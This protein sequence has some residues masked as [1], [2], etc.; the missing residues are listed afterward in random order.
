MT[1][2]VRLD[3]TLVRHAAAEGAVHR[4]STPKQIEYWAEIG[5]AV[6]GDVSAEDLIAILQGI[7]QVRVEP[8]VAESV[9]SDDLWAEVDQARES[10]NLGRSIARGRTVYQASGEKPGYL[11]AIYPDGTR[12]VGQFRNGRF[13]ALSDRDNAA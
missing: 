2:A 11:E 6:A 12:E 3:D 10:G 9:S 5:R 7:R 1:T 13:E 8:V 4:R